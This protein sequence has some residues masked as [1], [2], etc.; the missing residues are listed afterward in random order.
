VANITLRS[1][2]GSALTFQEADDNFTN[3]NTAKLESI[4]EDSAPSL[5]GNLNVSGQSIV[6]SSNGNIVIAPNGTGKVLLSGIEYPNV[7]GTAGQVLTTSGTGVASWQDAAGGGGG[8]PV[9]ILQT[10]SAHIRGN[11]L[12]TVRFNNN[13]F[14]IFNEE[15][16][17]L[18]G[19]QNGSPTQL[20]FQPGTY[21]LQE[22]VSYQQTSTVSISINDYQ[23]WN[24]AANQRF[25]SNNIIRSDA[26]GATAQATQ[27]NQVFFTEYRKLQITQTTT[28]EIRFFAGNLSSATNFVQPKHFTFIK[29]S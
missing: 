23:F 22:S 19:L 12:G 29:V 3:L 8:N 13:K 27:N 6:S 2:K 16:I 1:V 24:V 15:F 17:T 14:Q 11:N 21:I 20:T 18:G 5:G 25:G 9:E 26:F 7:N 28:L 4:S 10:T